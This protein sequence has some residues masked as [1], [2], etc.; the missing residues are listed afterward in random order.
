[1]EPL[2]GDLV[3]FVGDGVIPVSSQAADAGPAQE[4][5]S[6]LMYCAEGFVDVASRDQ[7]YGY[8]APAKRPKHQRSRVSSSVSSRDAVTCNIPMKLNDVLFFSWQDAVRIPTHARHRAR[9]DISRSVPTKT[10]WAWVALAVQHPP[11]RR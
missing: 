3:H 2:D 9:R 7:L 11:L 6:D 8:I 10:A 4:M 5:R 1:M